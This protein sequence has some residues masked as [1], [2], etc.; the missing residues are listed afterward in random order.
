V[1]TLVEG[2]SIVKL[3]LSAGS[4]VNSAKN[5]K[6]IVPELLAKTLKE[7]KFTAEQLGLTL[8]TRSDEGNIN[9][10]MIVAFSPLLQEQPL[11][12]IKRYR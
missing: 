3:Y 12:K 8:V 9:D 5:N 7:A 1:D 6:V 11:L 4:V 10:N 2:N